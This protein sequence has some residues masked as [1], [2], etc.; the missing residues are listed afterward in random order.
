MEEA[1]PTQRFSGNFFR[2]DGAY[3]KSETFHIDLSEPVMGILEEPKSS[4][5]TIT[6]QEDGE[7]FT[8]IRKSASTNSKLKPCFVFQNQLCSF[9]RRSTSLKKSKE[10]SCCQF[11][12]AAISL[13]NSWSFA[14][15]NRVRALRNSQKIA[16][17]AQTQARKH[18]CAPCPDRI[19]S[20]GSGGGR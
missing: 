11:I 2:Q 5:V 10:S 4:L 17:V 3:E 1:A 6:D 12:A 13:R 14:T 20:K 9:R 19:V 16:P 8:D 15:R 18:V 7:Y